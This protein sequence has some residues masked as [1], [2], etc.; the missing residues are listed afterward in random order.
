MFASFFLA[1]DMYGENLPEQGQQNCLTHWRRN[2]FNGAI[3]NEKCQ[4]MH[5]N[6]ACFWREWFPDV[7]PQHHLQNVSRAVLQ[8]KKVFKNDDL[9]LWCLIDKKTGIRYDQ[10]QN[11]EVM[12]L[13]G[14]PWSLGRECMCPSPQIMGEPLNMVAML[15]ARWW[16]SEI[17]SFTPK[18]SEI[19]QFWLMCFTTTWVMLVVGSD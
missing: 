15:V 5:W 6:K 14:H 7:T 11:S 16:V 10:L 12:R 3:R 17:V 1:C 4:P 13:R 8:K 2:G 9:T 19:E 18:L